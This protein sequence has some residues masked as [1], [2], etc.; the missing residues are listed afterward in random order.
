MQSDFSNVT[1]HYWYNDA[2]GVNPDTSQTYRQN[3]LARKYWN[4]HV[5]KL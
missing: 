5:L 2:T 4:R 3:E 1:D